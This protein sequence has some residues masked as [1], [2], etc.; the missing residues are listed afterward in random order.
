MRPGPFKLGVANSLETRLKAHEQHG[1]DVLLELY[2][3]ATGR[4]AVDVETTI[5]RWAKKNGFKPAF[6]KAQMRNGFSETLSADDVGPDFSLRP[7]VEAE[8]S[9]PL[10]PEV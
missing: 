6:T 1:F 10:R 8:D 5:L 9:I 3:F 7:F 4:E 2:E